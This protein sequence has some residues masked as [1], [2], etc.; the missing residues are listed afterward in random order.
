MLLQT[1][2]NKAEIFK[3]ITYQNKPLTDSEMDLNL[4]LFY[5]GR[6]IKPQIEIMLNDNLS[7][8]Y[9][10][11]MCNTIVALYADKWNRI[12]EIAGLDVS[13]INGESTTTTSNGTD[14]STAI[15]S[16]WGISD[17]TDQ[18][19]DK[20]TNSGMNSN[21]TISTKTCKLDVDNIHKTNNISLF[22][23]MISDV[24]NYFC[25]YIID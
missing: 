10:T 23:E 21:T 4:G 17:N 18:N 6:T 13:S 19:K 15:N 25:L 3:K 8:S 24:A 22:R 5:G 7:D 12:I 2:L 14:S 16:V 1:L 11:I 9:I 20:T